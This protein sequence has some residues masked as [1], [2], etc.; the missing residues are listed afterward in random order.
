MATKKTR[1]YAPRDSLGGASATGPLAGASIVNDEIRADPTRPVRQAVALLEK[2]RKSFKSKDVAEAR[3]LLDDWLAAV[4]PALPLPELPDTPLS[5]RVDGELGHE[6][7]ARGDVS[8]AAIKRDLL[9]FYRLLSEELPRVALRHEHAR[10]LCDYVRGSDP[11][12][13]PALFLATLEAQ[14][15]PHPRDKSARPNISTELIDHL[16][17]LAPA[18]L[19]AVVDAAQRFWRI[20]PRYEQDE[21]LALRRVGLLR[22]AGE[23]ETRTS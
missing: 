23:V 13:S 8:G 11:H 9:K 14:W 10:V 17:A 22:Q 5:V 12:Q 2:T 19:A 18:G 15:R 21:V 1:E 6:L 16:R 7:A 4:L 20:Y 3:A